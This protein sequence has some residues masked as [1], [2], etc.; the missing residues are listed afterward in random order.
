MITL[1][2]SQLEPVKDRVWVQ[3]QVVNQVLDQVWDRIS[4]QVWPQF[5]NQVYIQFYDNIKKISN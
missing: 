5:W 3:D 4:D 1:E 2:K